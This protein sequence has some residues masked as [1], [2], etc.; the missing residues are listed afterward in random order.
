MKGNNTLKENLFYYFVPM[1][2]SNDLIG[3]YDKIN[4]E[5]EYLKGNVES[6]LDDC[7]YIKSSFNLY[8]Y[9]KEV[10]INNYIKN[11]VSDFDSSDIEFIESGFYSFKNLYVNDDQKYAKLKYLA[12]KIKY[13]F[14]EIDKVIKYNRVI[15][16]SLSKI[17]NYLETNKLEE[18]D[19][20]FKCKYYTPRGLSVIFV[21]EKLDDDINYYS[22]VSNLLSNSSDDGIVKTKT[23]R[24]HID[25]L[26]STSIRGGNL[27][28]S[29]SNY[30]YINGSFE[31]NYKNLFLL[32]L[33]QIMICEYEN[34]IITEEIKKYDY[35]KTDNKNIDNIIVNIKRQIATYFFDVTTNVVNINLFYKDL[36]VNFVL[37][38]SQKELVENVEILN[39][40][41]N[42]N[43]TIRRNK[44]E[45]IG[46][47]VLAA[48]AILL[49]I[50]AVLQVV[51]DDNKFIAL[52]I[53]IPI[54]IVLLL[55]Y[56]IFNRKK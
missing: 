25:T 28:K 45:K 4:V 32:A 24:I 5:S 38:P 30:S 22:Q 42:E 48:Q 39:S 8:D 40:L 21:D 19:S 23:E 3:N 16:K 11:F 7:K 53:C 9:L 20:N 35:K 46:R 50:L 26:Y 47:E 55:I 36:L 49:I 56:S 15:F 44:H 33:N 34:E 43:M 6:I 37:E 2:I 31:N 54:G 13:K 1:V 52:A 41:V 17:D 27:I 18:I 14:N 51:T 10:K 29:S 12:I